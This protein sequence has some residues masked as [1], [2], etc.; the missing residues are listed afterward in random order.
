MD[1]LMFVRPSLDN[2]DDALDYIYEFYKYN[3]PI[4]GV[5][6]LHKYLDNYEGW[7]EKINKES[8]QEA[9]EKVVPN[10]TFFIYRENDNRLIGIVNIRK[11]LNE[12]YKRFGGNA[13]ASIRPT[14]R[15]K[16]Y[17]NIILYGVLKYFHALG[18]KHITLD[19]D[20]KNPSSR[21][22]I[23]SLGGVLTKK[24]Y[25][26]D[27]ET[28]KEDY[29]IDVEKSIEDF[30]AQYD[31]YI[32]IGDKMSKNE[33]IINVFYKEIVPEASKGGIDAW[34]RKNL[35]FS[36]TVEGKEITHINDDDYPELC[37]TSLNINN[38]KE[39][40]RLLC[41]YVN[42]AID[43]YNDG[44]LEKKLEDAPKEDRDRYLYKYII[45]SLFANASYYDFTNPISFLNHR[46]E[47]F[48][49]R[50]IDGKREIYLSTIGATLSFS[51]EK[52]PIEAETPYSITGELTFDDGY[53][54]P[55][56]NVYVGVSDN[57]MFIYGV[58]SKADKNIEI[59]KYY[60]KEIRKGFTSKING[61][62]EHYFL[63]DMLSLSLSDGMETVIVPFLPQR[64]NAKRLSILNKKQDEEETQA[65]IDKQESIQ[66]NLTEV[67]TRYYSKLE[68]I[69]ESL[70]YIS[71]PFEADD[72]IH[73]RLD[74]NEVSKCPVFNELVEYNRNNDG[75]R[76]R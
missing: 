38:K 36:T 32:S 53:K 60:L 50:I 15:G 8:T 52:A 28:F 34:F 12:R 26:D 3:S 68:A 9:T 72:K 10:D 7:L 20:E 54:L 25:I 49:N 18:V 71:F 73:L 33:E 37:V 51:E 2:K 61:A 57:K 45:S 35:L 19:C 31:D 58:L 62:P 59:N 24:T 56:P 46:I 64:W 66:T 76:H 5:N 30:K 22:N 23:K 40:D 17:S 43:F 74:P 39:F 70:N 63:S 75:V 65:E 1:K 16:K 27:L 69:S 55:L 29:D 21:T 14:E 48:K 4:E 41:E 44:S 47:M 13:G 6:G 67:L 11:E 42:M